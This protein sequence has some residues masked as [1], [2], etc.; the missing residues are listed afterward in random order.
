[1]HKVLE[2]IPSM[3]KK[4]KQQKKSGHISIMIGSIQIKIQNSS[5][6]E[7][8]FYETNLKLQKEAQHNM[9]H[10]EHKIH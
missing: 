8:I 5:T 3:A 4:K 1:M 7:T 2:L 10:I 9:I 6:P